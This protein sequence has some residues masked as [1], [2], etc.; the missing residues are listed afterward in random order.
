[1]LSI[2]ARR[3]ARSSQGYYGIAFRQMSTAAIE[4][5]KSPEQLIESYDDAE[6]R[7]ELSKLRDAESDL[8]SQI[9]TSDVTIDWDSWKKDIKY[10]N[11][12]DDMK[13][14]YEAA[15]TP[16]IEDDKT[17]MLKQVDSLFD[18]IIEQYDTMAKDAEEETL[19]LEEQLKEIQFVK[20]NIKD[21]SL[22]EFFKRYPTVLKS[23]EDDI[24][25]N[26]WFTE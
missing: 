25:Q 14:E 26:K 17:A 2:V 9:K 22:E 6:V 10:P 13:K 18:P 5:A 4:E 7:T 23:I 15:S 1:M 12:I 8:M 20:D 3:L 16:S 11:L 19:K 21:L 24:S